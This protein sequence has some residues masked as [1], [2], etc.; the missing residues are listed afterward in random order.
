MSTVSTKPPAEAAPIAG[1][2]AYRT[3]FR[4]RTYDRLHGVRI[5][6]WIAKKRGAGCRRGPT[7]VRFHARL[8]AES[9]AEA[10]RAAAL[11]CQHR[12]DGRAHDEAVALSNLA[13][14]FSPR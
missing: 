1:T 5:F 3:V 13:P 10:N 8:D 11:Y 4:Y 14:G 2:W 9:V 6:Q 7:V 12:N